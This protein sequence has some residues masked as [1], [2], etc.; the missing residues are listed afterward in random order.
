[1]AVDEVGIKPDSRKGR[2]AIPFC[3]ICADFVLASSDE[4]HVSGGQTVRRHCRVDPGQPGGGWI[5]TVVPFLQ[6][7]S[8]GQGDAGKGQHNND[9]SC[10][11]G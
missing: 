9:A 11:S 7:R 4:Y 10:L 5:G 8:D 1:M 3:R 6:A 2:I